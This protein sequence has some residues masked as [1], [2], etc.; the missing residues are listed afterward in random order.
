MADL[1]A[2]DIRSRMIYDENKVPEYTLPDPVKGISSAL[3]W[4]RR[5][6]ELLE[7]FSQT[8]YGDILPRPQEMKIEL[9]ESGNAFDGLAERRQYLVTCCNNNES[10]AFTLLLYLPAQRKG[11]VPAF[12]GLN[13]RG[14]HAL[15]S[16]EKVIPARPS[17]LET[18]GVA[19]PIADLKNDPRNSQ[20]ERFSFE[21]VLKRG[22]ASATVFYCDIFPDHR[23]GFRD[24]ALKLFYPEEVLKNP[25]K[26]TFGAISAWAWGLSRAQDCLETIPEIN[27]QKV[28]LHGHSRLGKTALWA[29]ACDQRFALVISNCSGEG[30]AA[31]SRR[32]FGE[33]WEWLLYWRTYWFHPALKKYINNENNLPFDQHQ[34]L[35]LISPRPLYV[36]SAT[37]DD[38]ADPR[39]EFTSLFHAGK[40]Y[41]LSGAD[42]PQ[43]MPPPDTP[44]GDFL[45][46]HIR[47]GIHDM[48]RADWLFYLDFADKW[49]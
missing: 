21:E 16:D 5:R 48:T 36:A 2:E 49:L 25:E 18:R 46:Y 10:I 1:I 8:M 4:N 12:L 13:F 28:A 38:G 32:C 47:T 15:T 3:D 40:V 19:R 17:L 34:L 31:L 24:S 43:N 23:E 20:S 26:H 22:Y 6:P 29:G 39:G 37:E 42:S 7:L 35:A 9:L 27:A 30:G 41:R 14:N 44:A 45:R 33:N 11:K